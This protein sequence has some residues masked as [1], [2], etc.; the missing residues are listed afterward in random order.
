[1]ILKYYFFLLPHHLVLH[2]PNYEINQALGFQ[3]FDTAYHYSI[4]ALFEDPEESI[5]GPLL[6]RRSA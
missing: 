4:L 2:R 1:V 6:C 3:I 5:V